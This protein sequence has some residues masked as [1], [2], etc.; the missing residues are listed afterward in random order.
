MNDLTLKQLEA[1]LTTECR[2]EI[3]KREDD[4]LEKALKE[5]EEMAENNPVSRFNKK[6]QE[7]YAAEVAKI[8]QLER[9]IS[10]A[11][12]TSVSGKKTRSQASTTSAK[13]RPSP[14]PL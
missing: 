1:E 12:S 2:A 7:S 9:D 4:A 3:R 5:L 13:D 14:L 10:W 8:D 6:L 11:E